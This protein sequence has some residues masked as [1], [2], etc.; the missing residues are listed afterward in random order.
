MVNS[1]DYEDD[2]LNKNIKI[3]IFG[4]LLFSN[5]KYDNYKTRN[6]SVESDNNDSLQ[7]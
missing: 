3:P 6:A 4:R 1:F 5:T 2:S 7:V